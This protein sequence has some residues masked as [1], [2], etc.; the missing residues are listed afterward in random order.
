MNRKIK[1]YISLVLLF[2]LLLQAQLEVKVMSFNIRLDVASDGENRWDLRKEKVASLMNYYEADFIGGQEVQHHQLQFLVKNLDGYAHI[3]VARDDGKEEGE[4][5]CIFYK[6]DRYTPLQQSTF[7]LSP[8][9]D[10]VSFGWNAACRRVCTYGLFQSKKTKQKFW[11]LN[12]H[13]D[14]ISALARLESAK[15]IIQKIAEQNAEGYP[16]ILTGDFNSRPDDEPSRYI[17]KYMLNSRSVS[18]LVYGGAD[19]WNAFKF[20]AKPDGCIDYI[21]VSENKKIR[22]MKFATLTDSY[23]LKYPSDHFPIMA[24]LKI[25]K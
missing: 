18:A 25:D 6:K 17:L 22:V 2:P 23:D 19:T 8:W 4:Y 21:F 3:G 20:N 9:P 1:L 10:S 24:T 15:L 11:V 13:F 5:S 14:H 12:T 16:V 7:W